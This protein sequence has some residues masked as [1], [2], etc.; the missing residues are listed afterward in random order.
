MLSLPPEFLAEADP[1]DFP[2]PKAWP[3]FVSTG[4]FFSMLAF[5]ES[6]QYLS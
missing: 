6:F 1:S 3:I 4:A 5:L 2:G